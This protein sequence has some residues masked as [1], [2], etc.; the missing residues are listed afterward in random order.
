MQSMAVRQREHDAEE[1]DILVFD[2]LAIIQALFVFQSVRDPEIASAPTNATARDTLSD[3]TSPNAL[4]NLTSIPGK[5]RPCQRKG[6]TEIIE[7]Y[8]L[9][10]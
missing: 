5:N 3:L 8:P 4:S 7:Q 10:Q 1:V 9:V 6:R 2:I